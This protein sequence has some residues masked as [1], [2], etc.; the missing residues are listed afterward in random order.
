MHALL[1]LIKRQLA[2]C[3]SRKVASTWTAHTTLALCQTT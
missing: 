2:W 3:S 1:Y